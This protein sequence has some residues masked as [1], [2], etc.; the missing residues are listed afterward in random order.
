M[1]LFESLEDL[2]GVFMDRDIQVYYGRPSARANTDFWVSDVESMG[3][4]CEMN[5]IYGVFF[6]CRSDERT[7]NLFS[8]TKE[9]LEK[10]YK[11]IVVGYTSGYSK[12]PHI[13]EAFY[14]PVLNRVIQDLREELPGS[15]EG[16]PADDEDEVI[17]QVGVWAFHQGVR[18]YT[19]ARIGSEED[20]EDGRNQQALYRKYQNKLTESMSE[21][22]TEAYAQSRKIE[23]EKQQMILDELTQIVRQDSILRTLHTVKARNEYADR[24][25]VKWQAERGYEW[26]TKKAVRAVVELEY[27]NLK[28]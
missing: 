4:Y 3:D 6:D 11:G 8:R 28:R 14:E 7:P 13:E 2:I 27:A 21:R 19:F 12:L 20:A 22:R 9:M 24:I 1:D 15:E 23:L 17:T 16:S 18:L 5:D 26:L 10:R 25:C